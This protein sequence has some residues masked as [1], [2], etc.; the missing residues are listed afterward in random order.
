MLRRKLM[1]IFMF[2]FMKTFI[3]SKNTSW[4]PLQEVC[5]SFQTANYYFKNRP[6]SNHILVVFCLVI[7]YSLWWKLFRKPP[8]TWTFVPKAAYDLNIC[9][10]SRLWPEHLFRKAPM[11]WTF[12]PKAAYDLNICSESRLWPEHLFWKP[13]MTWTFVPKAA[14]DLNICSE[15]R[16]WP[17][18]TSTSRLIFLNPMRGGHWKFCFQSQRKK[19]GF[20]YNL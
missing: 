9:S 16:L 15:S 3:V 7:Y 13:P 17:E 5:S 1:T 20:R 19:C 6:N 10:E 4:N 12:V 14:Y 18:H 11:T 8:M 2:D